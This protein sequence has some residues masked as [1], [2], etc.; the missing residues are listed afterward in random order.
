MRCEAAAGERNA[1][2]R[3]LLRQLPC[4]GKQRHEISTTRRILVISATPELTA[5]WLVPRLWRVLSAAPPNRRAHRRQY[6]LRGFPP[7]RHRRRDPA[8]RR[9]ASRASRRLFSD[10]HEFHSLDASVPSGANVCL[11]LSQTLMWYGVTW[12]GQE[13]SM[14]LPGADI[15]TEYV[16]I[17]LQSAS[18]LPSPCE[19]AREIAAAP[20]EGRP[21]ASPSRSRGNS[22]TFSLRIPRARL[23]P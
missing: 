23:K 1:H 8:E 9:Q 11:S 16:A 17:F 10:M 19:F 12:P 15:G 6:G 3:T 2:Q 22:R 21:L 20:Q 4:P 18:P 13:T 7:R 14:M 5:K